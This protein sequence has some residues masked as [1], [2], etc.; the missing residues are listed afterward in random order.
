MSAADSR[1]LAH[2]SAS[3]MAQLSSAVD[4]S[5]KSTVLPGT[6]GRGA[7]VL[8]RSA[9]KLG[10]KPPSRTLVDRRPGG[11]WAFAAWEA[12]RGDS[13]T[14]RTFG[15]QHGIGEQRVA[16]AAAA[17]VQLHHLGCEQ[18]RLQLLPFPLEE[19]REGTAIA[20]ALLSTDSLPSD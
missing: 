15:G 6:A 1:T 8:R 10:V 4:C 19:A 7:Q 3:K 5:S 18:G 12:I 11:L 17:R 9:K 14:Q 16:A 2:A 13:R 20:A